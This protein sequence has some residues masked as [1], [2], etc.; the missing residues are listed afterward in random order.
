MVGQAET[1]IQQCQSRHTVYLRKSL[2][3][4]SSFPFKVGETLVVR[5]LKNRIVIERPGGERGEEE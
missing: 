4:D 1:K 2:V 3:M 5:I